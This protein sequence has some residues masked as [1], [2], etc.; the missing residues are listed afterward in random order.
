MSPDDGDSIKLPSLAARELIRLLEELGI[1]E[2]DIAVVEL[3]LGFSAVRVQRHLP[4]EEKR[5]LGEDEK[6]GRVDGRYLG[7]PI[8]R[9]LG[10]VWASKRMS[11]LASK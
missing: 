5:T 9:A 1:N 4:R 2:E 3:P 6:T 8:K 7:L 10:I 11:E